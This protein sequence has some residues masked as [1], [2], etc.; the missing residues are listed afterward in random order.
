MGHGFT[1][2]NTDLLLESDFAMIDLKEA[3][4]SRSR[5]CVNSLK[6]LA[7][8]HLENHLSFVLSD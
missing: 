3:C 1:Q 7:G 8:V 6:K 4:F 2:M 5:I